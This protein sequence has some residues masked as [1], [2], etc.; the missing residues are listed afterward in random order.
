VNWVEFTPSP[1]DG[2]QFFI[3]SDSS[4]KP[5]HDRYDVASGWMLPL[6]GNSGQKITACVH[7]Y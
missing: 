3:T 5:V 1:S 6:I 4:T 7:G 2:Y